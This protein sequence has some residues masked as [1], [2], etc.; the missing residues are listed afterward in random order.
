M[1][2]PQNNNKKSKFKMWLILSFV[3]IFIFFASKTAIFKSII[4]NSYGRF[5]TRNI[6]EENNQEKLALAGVIAGLQ[7]ENEYLK[8]TEGL[9]DKK[10]LPANIILGGGYLFSDFLIL[11]I[12][13]ESGIT[14]GD[15]VITPENI[16]LGKI[17]E[18]GNGW[19]RVSEPTKIGE[20]T[21]MRFGENKEV[22]SEGVGLGAEIKVSLPSSIILKLGDIVW[23]GESPEILLGLVSKVDKRDGKDLQEIV[24]ESPI[25]S[26]NIVRAEVIKQ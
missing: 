12:G 9:K 19:S 16:Y 1:I 13:N 10:I 11:D 23:L 7:K 20:F 8:N 3:S 17:T 21:T 6:L 5:F 24:V 26:K 15:K 25:N 18:T 2:Y 14:S 22:S 4:F